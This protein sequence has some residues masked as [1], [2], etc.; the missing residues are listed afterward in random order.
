[1]GLGENIMT[2]NIIWFVLIAVLYAGYFVL[3]GFDFG[4]GILLPFLGKNNQQRRVILNTIGPHWDGNEVWLI[5]AGGATFAAFPRWYATLFSGF[6]L[7]LFLILL[8]LIL[9]GVA[10]EFRGK[11]NHPLWRACCDW[12]IFVGSLLPAIL[13]GVAFAN[14]VRGVPIDGNMNYVGGFWNLLNP[15]ALL[16]GILTLTSFILQGAVFLSL[17]TTGDLMEKSRKTAGGTWFFTILA[18]IAFTVYSFLE[19]GPQAK[20]GIFAW[21]ISIV[22]ILCAGGAGWFI[23]RK[24]TGKAFVFTTLAIVIS[25]FSLFIALFPRV[26]VS[27]LNSAWSLTIENSASNP[28]TLEVMTIIAVI[29][30]PLALAYQAWSYRIFRKRISEDQAELNY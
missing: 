12:S 7:P 28:Y 3:E 8:A 29:F 11:E 9:R 23:R 26:M 6:Y 17:K 1:M 16:G 14:I 5:T 22:I 13:W 25:T 19:I 2:F 4:V 30:L 20:L 27:S 21:V 18:L 24:Q 10:I 15:Y